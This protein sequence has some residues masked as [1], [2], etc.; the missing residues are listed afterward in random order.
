MSCLWSSPGLPLRIVC[1]LLWNFIGLGVPWI[2]V[3]GLVVKS[4]LNLFVQSVQTSYH[5]ANASFPAA[6]IAR[7]AKQSSSDAVAVITYGVVVLCPGARVTAGDSM[8]SWDLC[9]ILEKR[10]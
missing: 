1:G 2:F 5:S 7:T 3:G 8:S 4:L 9:S 10:F 6:D